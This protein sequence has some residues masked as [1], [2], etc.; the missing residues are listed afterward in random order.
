MLNNRRRGPWTNQSSGQNRTAPHVTLLHVSLKS[1]GQNPGHRG[2]LQ[3]DG[4]P[5]PEP[6]KNRRRGH[7]R[8][9]HSG[10]WSWRHDVGC[11]VCHQV[12]CLCRFWFHLEETEEM[13]A[14]LLL[15][16][17]CWSCWCRF[18]TNVTVCLDLLFTVGHLVFTSSFCCEQKL[19]AG[20][21]FICHLC[22]R[23]ESR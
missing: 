14:S 22:Q 18:R 21:N 7:W 8:Q 11:S 2:D 1:S 3:D 4:E 16:C 13:K 15:H 10:Q 9:Q 19:P 23:S 20:P 6:Q 12:K 5:E 17:C